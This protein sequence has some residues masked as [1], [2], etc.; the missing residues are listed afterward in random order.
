VLVVVSFLQL[1]IWRRY[2]V[3]IEFIKLLSAVL[4]VR[5]ARGV[6]AIFTVLS[7]RYKAR[8]VCHRLLR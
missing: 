8:T 3:G 5:H 6:K 4:E 2:D 7:R 1:L